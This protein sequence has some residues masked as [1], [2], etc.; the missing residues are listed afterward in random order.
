[1]TGQQSGDNVRG[2][3]RRVL[4][5]DTDAW[6]ELVQTHSGLMLAIAR[7]TF[8]T[9]GFTPAEVDAEDVVAAAWS[10]VLANDR[11]II[12]QCVGKAEW[13]PML[14]VLVRN[15]AVDA[16]R[17]RR[18]PTVPLDGVDVPEP[19]P[20]EPAEVYADR[21]PALRKAMEALSPREQ[22]LVRL[23]FIQRRKYREIADLTGIAQ[24]SIGP[25]LGRALAK[26]RGVLS[27]ACETRE[28][29]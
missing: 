2:L 24:N 25:T 29:S 9:Y 8:G 11:R 13:L 26:L 15:R 1:M 28:K 23:F 16:M 20:D 12:R 7:R 4:D 19:R 18:I 17:A 21:L 5:D 14:C 6:R 27:K 3:L 10:S 22:T